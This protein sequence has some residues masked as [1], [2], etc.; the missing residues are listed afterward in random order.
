MTATSV[1]IILIGIFIIINA[2]NF[3]GVI[4]GDKKLTPSTSSST[5]TGK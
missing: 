1:L 4:N 5:T 2:P 3:V